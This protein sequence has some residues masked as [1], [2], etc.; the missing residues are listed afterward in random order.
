[1]EGLRSL[2]L[3]HFTG[4]DELHASPWSEAQTARVEMSCTAELGD[5]LIVMR[6]TETRPA[7]SFDALNVFMTD[8]G[9][10]EVLLYGFDDLGYPPEPPARGRY[11]NA[12]IDLLRSTPRGHSRTTFTGT[13]TGLRWSKQFRPAA[14]VAWQPV[15]TG[16]L[17]RD[18]A[19]A[20]R[21]S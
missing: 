4:V 17:Q 8:L 14:D 13:A 20:D 11:A 18:A 5:A 21:S 1:M 10:G 7:G 19:A 2:L 6:V 15:V 9:T 3:G 16:T 12:Q